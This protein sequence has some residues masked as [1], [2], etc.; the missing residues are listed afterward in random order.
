MAHLPPVV[1]LAGA[2]KVG[3]DDYYRLPVF[4]TGDGV[5]ERNSQYLR[6]EAGCGFDFSDCVGG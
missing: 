3:A 6:S 2:G 4:G 5:G 1:Q